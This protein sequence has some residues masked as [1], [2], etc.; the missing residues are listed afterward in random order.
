MAKIHAVITNPFCKQ[1]PWLP[2]V[3]YKDTVILS[4]NSTT[5]DA[6][7]FL[8]LLCWY[9]D[10]DIEQKPDKVFKKLIKKDEVAISGGI[11]FADEERVITPS[12]CCGLEDWQEVYKSVRGG[13]SPWLGH[14][15]Y[16]S[17]QY[18]E[19]NVKVWS[20]DFSGKW[21]KEMSE[22]KRKAMF[23]ISYKHD[24]L[25]SMLRSVRTDLLDFYNYSFE[26]TFPMV[27]DKLKRKLFSQYGKWFKLE[28]TI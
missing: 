28:D 9:N 21:N 1:P 25:I 22:E 19:N 7:L 27:G 16:P 11:A 20:D 17:L 12:C 26:Q 23:C 24:E 15:P 14:D 6:V 10:I 4:K 13:T 8:T 18:E 5:E 2:E 3:N